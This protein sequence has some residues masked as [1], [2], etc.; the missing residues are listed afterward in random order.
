VSPNVNVTS[1]GGAVLSVNSRNRFIPGAFGIN[2][3]LGPRRGNN[4]VHIE[5]GSLSKDVTIISK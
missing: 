2:L 5:V 4:T 1:G 3:R